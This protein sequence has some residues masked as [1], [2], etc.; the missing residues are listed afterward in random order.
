MS[1]DPWQFFSDRISWEGEIRVACEAIDAPL[2]PARQARMEEAN[3][4]VLATLSTSGE[5]GGSEAPEDEAVSA[6]LVR[7]NA[8]LDVLMEVFNRHLLGNVSLPPRSPVR[9]N[10]RGILLKSWTAPEPGTPVSVRI[11]FDACVGLPLELSGH[12]ATAPRG[13]G[14]FVAFDG[15][16]EGIRQSIEHLVFR[17]HRRQLAETRRTS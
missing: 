9:F 17:Q 14:G 11:Y 1:Q 10:A 16:D 4:N 8:K 15:L 2:D 13:A 12:V 3:A 5:R 7:I 6:A